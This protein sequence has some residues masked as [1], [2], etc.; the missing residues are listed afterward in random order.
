MSVGDV[1]DRENER[2]SDRRSFLSQTVRT[3][4]VGL[5]L[6]VLGGP[7]A[8]AAPSRAGSRPRLPDACQIVCSFWRTGCSGGQSCGGSGNTFLCTSNG[9]CGPDFTCCHSGTTTYCLSSTC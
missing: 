4:G 2:I 8:A 7:A 5:G 6:A 3:I 1:G 9:V